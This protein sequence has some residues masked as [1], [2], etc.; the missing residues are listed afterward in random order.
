MDKGTQSESKLH[1]TDID[2]DGT[3][4]HVISANA[5]TEA[6]I[7]R[8]R[9]KRSFDSFRSMLSHQRYVTEGNVCR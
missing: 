6:D 2:V 9:G 8:F 3:L 7:Q 5:P 1:Y 4:C